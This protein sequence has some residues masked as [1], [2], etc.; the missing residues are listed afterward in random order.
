M[1]VP[2]LR[3]RGFTEE[4]E[5]NKLEIDKRN[6]LQEIKIN[7]KN[8]NKINLYKKSLSQWEKQR[9]EHYSKIKKNNSLL[10]H[11]YNA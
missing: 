8:K 10:D 7:K 2:K 9:N 4:W 5:K 3:F 1:S 11:D 6:E